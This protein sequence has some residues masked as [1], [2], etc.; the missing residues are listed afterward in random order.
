MKELDVFLKTVVD[1]MK[2]MAQGVESLAEKLHGIAKARLD[3]KAKTKPARKTPAKPKKV[4]EKKP[5]KKVVA[6]KPEKKVAKA[7]KKTVAK[8]PVTAVDTVLG[9]INTSKKGV[10][11]ATLVKKTGY[12]KKKVA[13][14]VYKLKK[15]GKIKSVGIGLY[16]KA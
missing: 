8:K 6:K 16:L 1:G 4:V 15:Q 12:D 7:V 10:D 2:V 9:I 5:V 13:N 14:L 11:T 3:E